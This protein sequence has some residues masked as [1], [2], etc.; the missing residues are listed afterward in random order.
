[1]RSDD[2]GWHPLSREGCTPRTSS[3]E[4]KLSFAC[5]RAAVFILGNRWASAETGYSELR[6]RPVDGLRD[7][8]PVHAMAPHNSSDPGASSAS[9]ATQRGKKSAGRAIHVHI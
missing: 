3:A 4:R 8:E 2:G 6:S 1:M 9:A 5:R 7:I